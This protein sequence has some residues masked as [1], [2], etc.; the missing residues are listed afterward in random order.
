MWSG[1]KS[2]YKIVLT[3]S[4]HV[5]QG[6][7][8]KSLLARMAIYC[9]FYKEHWKSGMSRRV[10]LNSNSASYVTKDMWLVAVRRGFWKRWS[11]AWSNRPLL[12]SLCIF[13]GSLCNLEQLY[14]HTLQQ[15][16]VPRFRLFLHCPYIFDQFSIPGTGI[17][18][19]CLQLEW[20][21]NK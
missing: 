14:M 15:S 4:P 6:Q 12:I 9:L 19:S 3:W 1:F 10:L 20:M 7:C 17:E 5:D 16:P 18:A 2:A 11:F 8:C 21:L 13:V